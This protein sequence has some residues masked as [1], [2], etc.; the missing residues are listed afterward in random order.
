MSNFDKKFLDLIKNIPR[1]PGVYYFY[2]KNGK[3][4]YIGKAASLRTR[5]GSY[6]QKTT[7]S[8]T[9]P[10]PSLSRRGNMEPPPLQGGARGGKTAA[11]VEK[12]ADI[13]YKETD[14]VLEALI[15]EANEIK[16]YLPPYNIRAKD[17]KTFVNIIIT[18]E[19]FPRVLVTRP[20]EDLGI[21]VKKIYGPY[22]SAKSA[23]EALKIIRKV[24]PYHSRGERSENK[25]LDFHL[26]L[27]PGPNAGAI[28]RDD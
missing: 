25:C 26:G 13:K 23:R 21:K 11:L 1:T 2:D 15:L 20:T 9:T 22:T 8:E 5:V 24:I 4:L 19:E 12:I 6:F 17:D 14:S 16:K 18:D 7:P 28:S 3:L 10:F 27:C